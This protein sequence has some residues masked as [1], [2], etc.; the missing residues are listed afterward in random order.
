VSAHHRLAAALAGHF[1]LRAGAL[2]RATAF[3]AAV[4][5]ALAVTDEID[6]EGERFPVA[7]P[8]PTRPEGR[9]DVVP[10]LSEGRSLF[11]AWPDVAA[12]AT[13]SA[14]VPDIVRAVHYEPSGSETEAVNPAV[15]G[16]R[17]RMT[18]KRRRE[19]LR[20]AGLRGRNNSLCFGNAG[21]VDDK[22]RYVGRRWVREEVRP[23]P[24]AFFPVAASVAAGARLLLAI[25]ERRVADRG[26]VVAYMDTDSTLIPA[27]TDGGRLV[28]GDGSVVREL[29]LAEVDDVFTLFDALSLPD[30][31]VWKQEGGSREEPMRAVVFGPK[32]H[33]EFIGARLL[34]GSDADLSGLTLVDAT[35]AQLG[36]T[37]VDPPQIRGPG[38]GPRRVPEVVD[39]G[40]A[41][42]GDARRSPGAWGG[43]C[44][45]PSTVG[46][47]GGRAV[48]R[49][50]VLRG[51]DAGHVQG[52]P[53]RA[54]RPPR[55]ALSGGRQA[56]AQSRGTARVPRSRRGPRPVAGLRL[57]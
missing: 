43:A 29:S 40:G 49:S 19:L 50:E 46:R 47:R 11:F 18:A 13:L 22:W 30:W 51:Q 39:G 52:P 20:A 3:R 27:T 53:S 23:G 8:D 31:P 14:R 25:V 45:V 26:G 36:G 15:L 4:D 12:A 21:R 2:V 35:E 44:A 1:G 9:L 16:V 33:A 54:W 32:R 7:V 34:E 17:E 42:G 38:V 41:P 55:D 5:E 57:D 56:P 48:P 28:L 37:Y 24:W 10:V 6:V